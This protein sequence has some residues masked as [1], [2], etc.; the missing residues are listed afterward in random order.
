[1]G[2]PPAPAHIVSSMNRGPRGMNG[3]SP[4]M[5]AQPDRDIDSTPAARPTPIS[6]TAIELETLIAAVRDE[7]QKRLTL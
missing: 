3:C 5:K 7:A 1:M 4:F 6:P 2:G